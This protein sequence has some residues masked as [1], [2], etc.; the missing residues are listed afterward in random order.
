M[1]QSTDVDPDAE[2]LRLA[3][4]LEDEEARRTKIKLE[5]DE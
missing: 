4:Q 2:S 5:K 1:S 3:Q